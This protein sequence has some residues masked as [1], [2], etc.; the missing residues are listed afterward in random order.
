MH[1][2]QQIKIFH[3]VN[4]F[5]TK[6]SLYFFDSNHVLQHL[7]P[8]NFRFTTFFLIDAVFSSSIKTLTTKHELNVMLNSLNSYSFHNKLRFNR[9]KKT[10]NLLNAN[11]F[12]TQDLIKLLFKANLARKA[13][14]EKTKKINQKRHCLQRMIEC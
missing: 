10:I 7:T 12:L 5:F 14:N 9:I 13:K 8:K 4:I 11:F 1:K 3:F 6:S 2:S